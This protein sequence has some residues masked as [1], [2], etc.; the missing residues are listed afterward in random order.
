MEKVFESICYIQLG[1][2]IIGQLIIT[3][4]PLLATVLFCV[5]NCIAVTR[6]IMLRRP[7]S[8][9]IKDVT[10]LAISVVSAMLAIC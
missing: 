7:T 1:L 2:I 3:K 10:M 6:A 8:D 9:K 4:N 5:G